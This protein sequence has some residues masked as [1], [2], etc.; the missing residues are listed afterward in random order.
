MVNPFRRW[1]GGSRE[2]GGWPEL[3]QWARSN[4]QRFAPVRDGSGFA[5]EASDGAAWRLEWGPPQRHYFSDGE[6]RIRAE[7]GAIGDLQMLVMSRD[8]MALLEQQVFDES[9][10]GTETR[11]DDDLPEEMRWLVLYPKVP[12]AVLGALRERFGALSNLPR[13][14]GSWL[15]GPLASQL[16]ATASWLSAKQ[17]LVLVVQRGR[18]TLRC[19]LA[20]PELPSLKAALALF[21][22]ALTAAR[23]VGDRIAQGQLG[24]GRPSTWGPPS[25]LPPGPGP[26]R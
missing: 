17:S 10:D 22:V 20:Q 3:A 18:L 6:L 21:G 8:L 1:F 5:I 26:G 23:G 11:M 7:V 2:G 4:G 13:A 24:D 16:E 19:A 25:A 14:A 15:E 12:R 9:T